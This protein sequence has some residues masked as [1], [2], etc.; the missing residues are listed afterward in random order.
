M[1]AGEPPGPRTLAK[2]K[3]SSPADGSAAGKSLPKS[4]RPGP[5]DP[6]PRRCIDDAGDQPLQIR[7]LPEDLETPPAL[8]RCPQP[9][10]RLQPAEMATGVDKGPVHP[11]AEEAAAQRRFR[12]VQHPEERAFFSFPRMSLSQFPV[13]PGHRVSSGTAHW[14]STT[15]CVEVG[16]VRSFGWR[17]WSAGPCR[18]DEGSAPGAPGPALGELPADPLPGP[19]RAKAAC[20]LLDPAAQLVFP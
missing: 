6:G 17:K 9:A 10:H 16:Q 8:R 5:P 15:N 12:L 20:N 2:R 1:S 14:R 3:G 4:R 7:D 19:V 18:L 13:P 11:A